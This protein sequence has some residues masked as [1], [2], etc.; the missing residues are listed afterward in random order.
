MVKPYEHKYLGEYD[1]ICYRCKGTGVIQ[2]LESKWWQ[3]WKLMLC[4]VCRGTG[5]KRR[6]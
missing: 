3:F 5:Y 4:P 6:E 1:D 2:S